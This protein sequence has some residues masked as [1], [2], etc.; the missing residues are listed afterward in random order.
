[1]SQTVAVLFETAPSVDSLAIALARF[2]PAAR[3]AV[4]GEFAWRLSGP[5]FIVPFQAE[6][7]GFALVDVCA[8]P[9]PDTMGHTQ[10][11]TSTFDGWVLGHFGAQTHPG[12]LARALAQ[13]WHWSSAPKAVH[14]HRAFVRIR[15]TYVL[16]SD[17]SSPLRPDEW[18]PVAEMQFVSEIAAAVLTL[19]SALAW[20]VPGGEVLRS[21]AQFHELRERATPSDP[22]PLTLWASVR[23]FRL[24]A[25]P[26]DHDWTLM[27]TVGMQQFEVTDHE[28]LFRRRDEVAAADVDRFLRNIALYELRAGPVIVDRDTADGPDGT[29]WRARRI[30]EAHTAPPRAVLRWAR[31][32]AEVPAAL[33]PGSSSPGDEVPTGA[34]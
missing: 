21:P 7:N 30:A 11:A 25:E 17:D 26:P 29:T 31:A 22:L 33:R 20:F 6:V 27:D 3:A 24:Q 12:S 14:T 9:W 1:M 10:D 18:D 13:P 16:G 28:A 34:A 8:H 4:G 19:P 23:L 2:T 15:T 32:N 5:G